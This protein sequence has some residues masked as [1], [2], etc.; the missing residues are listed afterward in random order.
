MRKKLI[1]I[2]LLFINL[3]YRHHIA[4]AGQAKFHLVCKPSTWFH[5]ACRALGLQALA[6]MAAVGIFFLLLLNSQGQ[7]YQCSP[8]LCNVF[9]W[10]I[11]NPLQ[12]AA[13]A[14]RRLLHVSN[15]ACPRNGQK[16]NSKGTLQWIEIRKHVTPFAKIGP[17]RPTR[18]DEIRGHA[19]HKSSILHRI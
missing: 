17:C 18:L 14:F 11:C 9:C 8:F 4:N 6:V 7:G 3:P 15:S 10:L 16:R 12:P 19:C 13:W 5:L 1:Y 2:I